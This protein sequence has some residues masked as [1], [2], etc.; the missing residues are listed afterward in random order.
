MY[1]LSIE[2]R[3]EDCL[4]L[5]N[6]LV[7][8]NITTVYQPIVSL[9][10]GTVIGYEALS[11]GPL[12]S[13]LFFPDKL[14]LAA[15][16]ANKTMELEALC[17]KKA[18]ENAENMDSNKLLF[19]NVHPNIF[20][21]RSL[22]E[23]LSPEILK[24]YHLTP[25]RVVFEITEKNAIKD[26][27]ELQTALTYF[28]ELGHSIAIDDMGSGHSGL[29]LLSKVRPHFIKIDMELIRGIE[30]NNFNQSVVESIVNLAKVN[31][32][33]VIAE[34]IETKEELAE[35]INL[36]VH[37]GQGY[38][39]GIPL[40]DFK[41]AQEEIKD[42]ICYYSTKQA[43]RSSEC[44]YKSIG[45]IADAAPAFLVDTKC[46]DIR[47][48]FDTHDELGCCII[49]HNKPVGLVM[50][51]FLDSKLATLYGISVFSNRPISLVM[52][53]HPI[54]VDYHYSVLDVSKIAMNRPMHKIYDYIIVTKNMSYYGIVTIKS[55]LE[56]TTMIE[57][58]FARELNPLTALPGNRTIQ[59][60]LMLCIQSHKSYCVLYLDLDHF[61]AYNDIY[62][63]ENGDLI[64]KNT[65][66]IIISLVRSYCGESEFIG[67]IGGDDFVCIL[68]KPYEVCVLL[69]EKIL[70]NFDESMVRFFNEKDYK[71]GYI[72]G[73]NRSGKAE[74][75][76]LTS[77]S[78][79][80]VYGLISG[81]QTLEAIG[82]YMAKLKKKA[83]LVPKSSYIMET[84]N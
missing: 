73:I 41:E 82:A 29:N 14:F 78:I 52:D 1:S 71:N 63:F 81:F 51:H 47:R 36:G 44:D 8:E 26:L 19:I 2:P 17:R 58:N 59:N 30:K 27:N 45:E 16:L 57:R 43:V 20:C 54:I 75:F 35:L 34:G 23:E 77:L 21:H 79:A 11:R 4:E 50:K 9:Q 70:K 61:K 49:H 69:C 80:G 67:H 15:E 25:N 64:I 84:K 37:A 83:K 12:N 66:E 53:S 65:A 68:E 72:S 76:P 40:P 39:L 31:N 46:D 6:I 18:F 42:L 60:K 38:F 22:K 33:R 48:F 32:M 13:S 74:K 55:L 5:N 28:V 62:G 24:D 3:A 10:H 56:Y 7:S